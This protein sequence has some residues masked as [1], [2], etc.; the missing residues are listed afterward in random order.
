MT[1]EPTIDAAGGVRIASLAD[2]LDA[3]D[4]IARWHWEEW[5]EE[6]AMGPPAAWAERLRRYANRAAIP[7]TFVALAPDGALVGSASLTAEDLASRPDLSPW[8][9]SV[10][11]A[12]EWRGRGLGSALARHVVARAA[13]LGVPRLYLCT[14]HSRSLYERLGWRVV[15]PDHRRGH[16]LVVMAIETGDTV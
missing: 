6:V 10:Y 9:S 8:L 3:V 12:P 16:D 2:H 14:E 1:N 7:M 11:V 13:A 5:G 4:A 15:A